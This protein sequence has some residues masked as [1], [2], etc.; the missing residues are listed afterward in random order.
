[1]KCEVCGKGPNEV[2]IL[3]RVNKTGEQG[4]WRCREHITPDQA[5][6]VDPEVCRISNIIA[7]GGTNE[8]EHVH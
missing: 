7:S 8:S 5:A 3:L 6:K 1:M 2:A 4:I